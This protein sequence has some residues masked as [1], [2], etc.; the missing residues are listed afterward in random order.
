MMGLSREEAAAP[1]RRGARVRRARGVRRAE[2][3][4]LLLG[5]AGAAAF[6]VM[7]QAD[8]DI[9]LIDEVLAVGDA[10]FQQKCVDVFHEM[11]DERQDGRPRHP[12]HGRG[13]AA[14]ATG[15]CCSTTA[16]SS[17]S[18]TRTRSRRATCGSTSSRAPAPSRGAD[19]ACVGAERAP[20]R[21]LARGRRRRAARQRRAGQPSSRFRA[22]FEARRTSTAPSFGFVIVNADDVEVGGFTA[23]SLATAPGRARGR[24]ARARSAASREPLAAGPLLRRTA[25]SIA[26]ARSPSRLHAPRVLDFVV[27]GTDAHGRADRRPS[28]RR[29]DRAQSSARGR[30]HER[31]AGERSSCARSRG[32]SRARRRQAGASSSCSG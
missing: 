14:T 9:L 10:A 27:F 2:A 8:A 17:G 15:R 20:A 12:R 28:S 11:R 18:A 13:R 16:T 21:R 30:A 24:R 19:G 29:R 3:E 23:L 4:E 26:T 25:G 1:P 6:S 31:R 32:P 5:D 22:T 7:I